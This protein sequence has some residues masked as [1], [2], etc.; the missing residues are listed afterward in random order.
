MQKTSIIFKQNVELRERIARER[1]K[2]VHCV[3]L[4]ESFPTSINIQNLA[5]IQPR[6]SPLEVCG[7]IQ[8]IIYS[9]ASLR[10]TGRRCCTRRTAGISRRSSGSWPWVRTTR[11]IRPRAILSPSAP[12]AEINASATVP[13]SLR[14]ASTHASSCAFCTSL[15]WV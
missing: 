10:T 5:S 12:V 1:C 2:G 8:I 13:P 4:G 15:C 14:A 9:F 3:D 11:P 7:K 6:T